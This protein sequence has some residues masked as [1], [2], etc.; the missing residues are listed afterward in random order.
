MN[1]R[2]C[3]HANGNRLDCRQYARMY[4]A[5]RS[6]LGLKEECGP[7]AGRALLLTLRR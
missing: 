1:G 5:V 3:G 4:G 7:D 2:R 6:M